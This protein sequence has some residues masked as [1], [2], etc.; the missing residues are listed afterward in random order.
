MQERIDTTEQSTQKLLPFNHREQHSIPYHF[1]AATYVALRIAKIMA[2]YRSKR[3]G[4]LHVWIP[5]K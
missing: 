2:E 5:I 4:E 3:Q 1:D